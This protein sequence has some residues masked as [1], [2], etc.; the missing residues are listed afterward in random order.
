MINEATTMS[1]SWPHHTAHINI[2]TT[3]TTTART[4]GST[5]AGA[6]HNTAQQQRETTPHIF[7]IKFAASYKIYIFALCFYE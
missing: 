3:H 2:N 6:A 1:C 4:A 7:F 5:T